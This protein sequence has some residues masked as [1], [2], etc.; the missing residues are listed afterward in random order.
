MR[1]S[2]SLAMLTCALLASCSPQVIARCDVVDKWSGACQGD[3]EG[4]STGSAARARA[5]AERAVSVASARGTAGPDRGTGSRVG[6][7]VEPGC[8]M[9]ESRAGQ[10]PAL[11]RR[12]S[13]GATPLALPDLTGR[14]QPTG[15][16]VHTPP[17]A[18]SVRT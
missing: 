15:S 3:H 4:G 7:G 13:R 1:M 5:G 10:R 8:P 9:A 17:S 14:A 12:L 18:S 16:T 2:K 11:P 6:G